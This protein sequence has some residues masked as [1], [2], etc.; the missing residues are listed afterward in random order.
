MPIDLLAEQ[1]RDLL[2]EQE[3][4]RTTQDRIRDAI[5][6][7]DSSID[8]DLFKA[9]SLGEMYFDKMDKDGENYLDKT[10]SPPQRIEQIKKIL[11]PADADSDLPEKIE[12]SSTI[13][14][15][16][17]EEEI[18]AYFE[19]MKQYDT[20]MSA[21]G[22]QVTSEQATET[23]VGSMKDNMFKNVG[24]AIND[25]Y[26]RAELERRRFIME[27]GGLM[28]R[29]LQRGLQNVKKSALGT[30][31]AVEGGLS[32]ATGMDVNVAPDAMKE[33]LSRDINMWMD[34]AQVPEEYRK[35]WAKNKGNLWWRPDFL[36]NFAL[37]A[38]P[39]MAL[40]MA[41]GG[42]AVNSLSK[43]KY[44][45]QAGKLFPGSNYSNIKKA[46]EIGKTVNKSK[47]AKGATFGI[48]SG[49]AEATSN[50]GEAVL[51][52]K[53][54]GATEEELKQV[55]SNVFRRDFIMS[56]TLNALQFGA[57]A[58]I[59]LLNNKGLQLTLGGLAMMAEGEQELR[60]DEIVEDAVRTIV[61]KKASELPNELVGRYVMGLLDPEKRDVTLLSTLMGVGDPALGYLS[62]LKNKVTKTGR[63]KGKLDLEIN[64]SEK[65]LK[66][67]LE[68]LEGKNTEQVELT[69]E[70][71]KRYEILKNNED[72]LIDAIPEL[73]D[74]E[75][76]TELQKLRKRTL[77]GVLEDST[78]AEGVKKEIEQIANPDEKATPEQI[79]DLLETA[80]DT[81]GLANK[82]TERLRTVY[83]MDEMTKGEAVSFKA[84]LQNAKQLKLDQQ[85][86]DI[87]DKI[88]KM[89]AD[90]AILTPSE[91][92]GL[93][94]ADDRLNAQYELYTEE[95]NKLEEKANKAKGAEK[96]RLEIELADKRAQ[97][98]VAKMNSEKIMSASEYAGTSVAKSLNARNIRLERE[99]YNLAALEREYKKRKGR[100]L[101]NTERKKLAK[102]SKE[103][104]Q[105]RQDIARLQQELEASKSGTTEAQQFVDEVV[106]KKKKQEKKESEENRQARKQRAL[107]AL[108]A[109]GNR[110][111][112]ITGIPAE[113][114]L[115]VGILAE[116]YVEEGIT[117]LPELIDMIK[118]D[119][120]DANKNDIMEAFAN[121]KQQAIKENL[122]GTKAI[123]K[124]L[125]KQAVLH[126]KINK[127]MEGIFDTYKAQKTPSK[128]IQRLQGELQKLKNSYAKTNV[129]QQKLDYLNKKIGELQD[130][131]E[132]GKRPIDKIKPEE[133]EMLRMKAK[134]VRELQ[135][136]M[137]TEDRISELNNAIDEAVDGNYDNLKQL[138]TPKK[139]EAV[140]Y[141][142][143][144][145]KQLELF[146]LKRHGKVMIDQASPVYKDIGRMYDAVS[147]GFMSAILSMDL[148]A[149][150][151]Q[152]K[153]TTSRHPIMS[154]KTL[155][156]V[157]KMQAQRIITPEQAQDTFDSIMKDIYEDPSYMRWKKHKLALTDP[158][159]GMT[160]R[161]EGFTS[162]DAIENIPFYGSR[163]IK[164]SEQ[165]HVAFLNLMRIGLFEDFA[166]KNPHVSDEVLSAWAKYVNSATG[167]GSLGGFERSAKALTRIFLAPR[168]AVS[169]FQMMG[170]TPQNWIIAWKYP[171]IRKEMAK[172]YGAFISTRLMFL[173][174]GAAGGGEVELEDPTNPDWMKLKF[175]NTRI[176]PW[177]GGQQAVRLY[178]QILMDKE[179]SMNNIIKYLKYRVNPFLSAA[180]TA[181]SGKN[182]VGQKMD[183]EL[184]PDADIPENFRKNIIL[185][186]M[187]PL[188]IQTSVE[189]QNDRG[190]GSLLWAVPAEFLGVNVTSYEKKNNKKT[191][192]GILEK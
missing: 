168:W 110:V 34:A 71:Q 45:A 176:D 127:A 67:E 129:N 72:N 90:R 103:I 15:P 82:D 92:T 117:K 12:Q 64:Y 157:L 114:A 66:T 48:V 101:T 39:T 55:A 35:T 159:E 164:G 133:H 76:K 73:Q 60:Q 132:S 89:P 156:K 174:L 185:N 97:A 126:D 68:V 87:A 54:Q 144:A 165:A 99:T 79:N 42:M 43:M 147:G 123:L 105:L 2:A 188:I 149:F 4:N 41:L 58:S 22:E 175:G 26:S 184:D 146:Q 148:G 173:A 191:K 161:E 74:M 16:M 93:I 27:N 154:T 8:T 13:R 183:W 158:I 125:K 180:F 98:D 80:K 124:E 166:S 150:L 142:E 53:E 59:K 33:Q 28:S 50:A 111:N 131:L 171:E 29:G 40:D 75:A 172:D 20:K 102:L 11:D 52:A 116:V 113:V 91:Y 190:V 94:I 163:L 44:F 36:V 145:K 189:V 107:D 46:I 6:N 137:K 140:I 88:L 78:L 128:E 162:S 84:T 86:L 109:M 70:E 136:W 138:I 65:G 77:Q 9:E 186:T 69:T 95:A 152:G 169:N 47:I 120:P 155:G 170:L 32:W 57:G 135:S 112:D 63:G 192:Y 3:S 17:T 85:A 37:E 167:R 108:K 96:K 7:Y 118:Q 25:A 51:Q 31:G 122:K 10:M 160:K 182:V 179:N 24:T 23:L 141:E 178:A 177:G 5:M 119:L 134:E 62:E 1:P 187:L 121:R 21:G 81:L 30:I 61:A 143:L 18:D 139:R 56:S 19:K 100:E 153:I 83:G 106:A 115:Q 181:R 38:G 130:M 151:R 49:M 14:K 104:K